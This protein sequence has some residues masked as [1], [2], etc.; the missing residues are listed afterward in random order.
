MHRA[1]H[2][3]IP[4]QVIEVDSSTVA[5]FLGRAADPESAA[6]EPMQEAGFQ[7]IMFTDMANSS[8]ITN[9]LGDDD[10]LTIL[11][12]HHAII[13]QAL[14]DHDGREVDRVGD[15]FLTCFT[16][17]SRAGWLRHGHPAGI[18]ILQKGRG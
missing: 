13:R 7:S 11:N 10:A 12:Q 15:G 17:V 1:S 14:L 2:G 9:S 8:D 4:N 3:L 5:G 6:I 18:R 16:T